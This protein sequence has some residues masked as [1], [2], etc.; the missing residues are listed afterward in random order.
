VAV[1]YFRFSMMLAV[2]YYHVVSS[3]VSGYL[4]VFGFFVL[5]G[6]LITLV[7]AEFYSS[8]WRARGMFLLNRVVRIYPVYGVC[9]ALSLLCMW[10][11]D[12]TTAAFHYA[13]ALPGTP[14]GWLY[15]FTI[16][17]L[18]NFTPERS[19]ERLLPPAWSLGTEMAYYLC[20]GLVTGASRRLTLVAF[21]ASVAGAAYMVASGLTFKYFYLTIQGPAFAFYLG[22]AACHYRALLVKISRIPLW[23]AVALANL[24][25]Y[26]PDFIQWPRGHPYMPLY[27]AASLF[28][29]WL[30]L[31]IHHARIRTPAAQR[32]ERWLADITYPAFLIHEP[33][34]ALLSFLGNDYQHTRALYLPTLALTLCVSHLIVRHVELP[35]KQVRSRIRQQ[36]SAMRPCET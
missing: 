16:L 33:L 2:V 20:I 19:P 32:L 21:L 29:A 3:V 30:V 8:G 28:F 24:V 4:A 35:L 13:Y 34:G 26:V 27:F 15:Q 5:S 1:G 9:L 17:G 36:A 14:S 22:A 6:Y 10:M 25:I 31:C 7:S 23:L 11:T 12:F 18:S